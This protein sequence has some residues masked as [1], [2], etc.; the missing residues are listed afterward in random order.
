VLRS[1]SARQAINHA[2]VQHSMLMH[3]MQLQTILWQRGNDVD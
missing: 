1:H 2:T 3:D